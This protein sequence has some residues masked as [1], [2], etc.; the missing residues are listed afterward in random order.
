MKS[1]P[2]IDKQANVPTSLSMEK[3]MRIQLLE[4][5]LLNIDFEA[6]DDERNSNK[7]NEI[8]PDASDQ[9]KDEFKHGKG[10]LNQCNRAIIPESPESNQQIGIGIDE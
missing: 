3:R 8:A 9:Q 1:Q 4:T 6:E 10:N 7:M 2:E 5:H